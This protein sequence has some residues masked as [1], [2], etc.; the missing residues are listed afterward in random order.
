MNRQEKLTEI[1]EF[2]ELY[3]KTNLVVIVEN[4]GLNAEQTTKLRKTVF[5]SGGQLRVFKN[6]FVTKGLGDGVAATIKSHLQGPNTFLFGGENFIDDLKGVVDFSKQSGD[7]LVVKAGLLDGQFLDASKLQILATLPGK[8]QLRAQLLGTLL[9]P[10]RG[11]VTALA[12]NVRN[13]LNVIN[14]I[15]EDKE[16]NS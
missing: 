8:D 13:L 9:G 7:K 4:R 15:K 1:Q 16:K 11:L 10:I 12:G 6:T 2:T 3:G 14:A 5:K